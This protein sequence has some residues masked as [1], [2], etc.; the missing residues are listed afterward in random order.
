MVHRNDENSIKI[1]IE[2]PAHSIAG[3][4]ISYKNFVSK[5]LC[6]S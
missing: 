2:A 4:S 6:L 3:A 1:L 5:K